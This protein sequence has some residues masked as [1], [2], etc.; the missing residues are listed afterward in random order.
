MLKVRSYGMWEDFLSKKGETSRKN[1]F[2][3]CQAFASKLP[4][5]KASV[6]NHTSFMNHMFKSITGTSTNQDYRIKIGNQT[7]AR[8]TSS[9]PNFQLNSAVIDVDSLEDYPLFVKRLS[10]LSSSSSSSLSS[11]SS[12]KSLVMSSSRSLSLSSLR[13]SMVRSLW[14]SLSSSSRT[15]DYIFRAF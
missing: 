12:W 4:V 15:L 6:Q 7:K 3:N 5:T 2:M 14:R 13:K 10:C 1:I 8:K 11:S 9:V